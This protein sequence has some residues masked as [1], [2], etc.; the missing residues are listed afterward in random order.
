MCDVALRRLSEGDIAATAALE[1]RCFAVPWSEQSLYED[2][3]QNEISRYFG[4]FSE[5]TLIAY[6][7][8]WKIFDEGHITNVAVVPERR[9]QG[10]GRTLL[11]FVL[12]V[13][14][15]EG[16]SSMT[17]EVR[18]SN[19]AALALYRSFG[20]QE[21]GRRKRYYSDNG[22]DALIYWLEALPYPQERRHML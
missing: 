3:V 15:R 21:K 20:F 13:A 5:N 4:L 8:Y 1:R 16:V 19:E 18:P 11:A 12:D 10:V 14:A 2:I 9:R 17:L 22:E 7:G 6:M